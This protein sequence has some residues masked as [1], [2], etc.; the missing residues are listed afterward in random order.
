MQFTS[1][2]KLSADTPEELRSID[3]RRLIDEADDQNIR[4]NFIFWLKN[5]PVSERILDML[6]NY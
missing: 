1:I 3:I 2:L 5:Q 6:K 4:A